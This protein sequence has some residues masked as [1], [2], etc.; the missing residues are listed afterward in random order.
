[1]N[2][3]L[4]LTILLMFSNSGGS[5]GQSPI[6]IGKL[7]MPPLGSG[8]IDTF[9]LELLLDRLHSMTSALE[10]VNHLNQMRNIP[11]N[12]N[13]SLDRVQESLDA[14]RGLIY[15]QRSNKQIDMISSAVSNVKRISDMEGM[16]TTLGPILSMLSNQNDK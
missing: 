2:P 3:A 6:R 1:M 9:R 8:Y 10:N 11:L 15:D 5:H 13:N 14:I 7:S 12:K 16:M 4:L